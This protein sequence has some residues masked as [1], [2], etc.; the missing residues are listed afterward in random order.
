MMWRQHCSF[1]DLAS[2]SETYLLGS[3]PIAIDPTS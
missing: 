3:V 2:S 1:G